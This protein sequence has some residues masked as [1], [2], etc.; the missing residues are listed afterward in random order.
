M[1]QY[2]FSLN[3]THLHDRHILSN[4]IY[5]QDGLLKCHSSFRWLSLPKCHVYLIYNDLCIPELIVFCIMVFNTLRLRQ[6]GCHFAD[7]LFKGIFLNENIWNSIKISLKFNP[8]GPID[9]IPALVHKMAWCQLGDKPLS[10]PMIYINECCFPRTVNIL[11]ENFTSKTSI[12]P[13]PVFK[14]WDSKCL[15]LIAQTVRVFG[16]NLKI[17]SSSPPQ[18]ETFYVPKTLTLSQEHPFVSWNWMLLPTH[19]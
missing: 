7:N 10:E 14:A 11:N 5:P 13:E 16:M 1:Q 3:D 15:A 17:G 18:V 12:P 4:I 6:N 2:T 19:S 9:N 8:K